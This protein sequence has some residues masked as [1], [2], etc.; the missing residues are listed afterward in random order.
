MRP[1]IDPPA[2]PSPARH[3]LRRAL[4]L[5]ALGLASGTVLGCVIVSGGGTSKE[6]GDV[7]THSQIQGDQCVCDAGYEFCTADPDDKSCCKIDSGCPDPNSFF[8]DG[9]CFCDA[10]Y[11]WCNPDDPNDLSCCAGGGS[12]GTTGGKGTAGSGTGGGMQCQPGNEPDP[13]DCS[14]ATEGSLF[15]SHSD[16]QQVGCATLWECKGGQ[17]VDATATAD[18]TCQ[19]DGWE[20]AYGCYDDA[21]AMEIKLVCGSGPKTDCD[22]ST[23]SFCVDNDSIHYC[24]FGK[25]T[26]ASCNEICQTI[27]DENLVTYDYGEC[28]EDGGAAD[29]FCC[30]IG[31]PGCSGGGT[32]GTTSGGLGG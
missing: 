18:A 21:M 13:A 32:G 23:A 8:S 27:G 30:D 26:E 11:S 6:C 20:W 3:G 9:Q 7:G 28:Q 12:G 31:D 10:G 4:L 25:L 16:P 1:M 14:A 2:R 15:C 24:R 17:W 19:F 29:C 5:G 22:D